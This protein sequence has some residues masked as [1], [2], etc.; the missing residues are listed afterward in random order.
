MCSREDNLRRGTQINDGKTIKN[1]TLLKHYLKHY[2]KYKNQTLLKYMLKCQG[3]MY[4]CLQL[5]LKYTNNKKDELI[6]D[7]TNVAVNNCRI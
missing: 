4:W 1:Q 2:L 6:V 5:T 7:K 3:G